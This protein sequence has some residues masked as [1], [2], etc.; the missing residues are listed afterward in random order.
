M[1]THNFPFLKIQGYILRKIIPA[2][3]GNIYAGLSDPDVIKYYGIS[4]STIADTQQ[5]MD[6]YENLQKEGAGIWWAIEDTVTQQFCGAAGLNNLNQKFKT[7]ELGYWLLPQY[8]RRGI[9]QKAVQEILRYSLNTLQLHRIFAHVET[10]NTA[11][12]MLLQR[13]G[14]IYEGTMQDCEIKNGAYISLKIYA[15]LNQQ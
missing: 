2:D 3:I 12:E 9:M 7:A 4:F 1:F 13:T 10:E 8:W 6:W 5:Q 15:I 14:F 11:S